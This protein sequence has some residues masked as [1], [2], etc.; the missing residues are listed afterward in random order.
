M[1]KI[2]VTDTSR[3]EVLH[4]F[5][6]FYALALVDFR[7]FGEDKRGERLQKKSRITELFPSFTK[8][9]YCANYIIYL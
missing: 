6:I 4:K 7:G 8:H 9:C 3:T 5:L 1:V 2:V